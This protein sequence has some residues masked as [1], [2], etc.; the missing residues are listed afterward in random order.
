MIK[1][2]VAVQVAL[3]FIL[4]PLKLNANPLKMV[5][6]NVYFDDNSGEQRYPKI[7]NWLAQ[8]NF[9]VIAL[10]EVTPKFLQ[11]LS[12]KPQFRDFHFIVSGNKFGGYTNI[13]LSQS[14]SPRYKVEPKHSGDISLT[15]FMGRSAPFIAISLPLKQTTADDNFMLYIHSLHLDSGLRDNELRITQLKEIGEKN[16]NNNHVVLAGDFN[17][18]D[19]GVEQSMLL[20]HQDADNKHQR[21][22]Y[23]IDNNSIAAKTKFS[24]EKSRR[25][26]RLLLRSNRCHWQNVD[27][28]KLPFSDHYPVTA[29]LRCK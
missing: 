12:T 3:F 26:D 25:L 8:Q 19:K 2:L 29:E 23:H 15:S 22:T 21:L 18:G 24:S 13:V 5:T 28:P 10:Q 7:L 17:F 14:I 4:V 9:D 6:Y 1:K 20:N 16:G 27:V 11:L